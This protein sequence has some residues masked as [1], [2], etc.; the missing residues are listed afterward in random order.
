MQAADSN[1]YVAVTIEAEKYQYFVIRA[2][3][4]TAQ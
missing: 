4:K 2:R 1:E 3:P